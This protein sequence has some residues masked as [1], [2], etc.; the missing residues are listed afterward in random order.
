MQRCILFNL[1]R[2]ITVSYTH[3]DVYKR[4]VLVGAMND[5]SQSVEMLEKW[6]NT[7]NNMNGLIHFQ[8]GFHAE[9]TTSRDNLEAVA[10]LAR[11]YR[12]PVYS[13]NS[14]T[15]GEVEACI[16][17]YGKTPTA[18]LDSLGMFD[19]GGGGYHCVY[20]S[21][22]D[23]EIFRTRGIAAVTNPASNL[24]LASGIAPVG[25]MLEMG[26]PIAIGTD[27]P[28]SNNCLDMFREMFLA[29]SYTHLFEYEEG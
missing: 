8:L 21:Q 12:A 29:V 18:F 2:R 25:K 5:F 17:R 19:Y 3:L 13:H 16:R 23:L 6:Y 4:Q 22:E 27:G 9:Y 20:M 7:Y 14:E 26:I 15:R 10:A 11:Q 24:K 1:G 28:A